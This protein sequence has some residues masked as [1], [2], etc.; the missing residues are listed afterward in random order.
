MIWHNATD[1]CGDILIEPAVVNLIRSHCQ[2]QP[3]ISESG[4]ILLGYR[5]GSHLHI[6][7]ATTPQPDDQCTRFRFFRRDL[8]HQQV[9]IS[10][11]GMSSN[12]LDYIGEWHTHPEPDPMPSSLDMSEWKKICC[13]RKTNMVFLIAGWTGVFWLGVGRGQHIEKATEVNIEDVRVE[14]CTL[15]TYQTG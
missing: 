6:V 5:R 11:W 3:G 2:N 14:I 13:A 1:N 7:D 8:Y 12:T 15:G 9:A 10:K 4:G